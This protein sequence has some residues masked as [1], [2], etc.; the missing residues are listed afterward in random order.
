[1][2]LRAVVAALTLALG[3]TATTQSASAA[4]SEYARSAPVRFATYNV[5][6]TPTADRTDAEQFADGDEEFTQRAGVIAEVIWSTAPDVI[7]LTEITS[8]AVEALRLQ[9]LALNHQ[10]RPA[11][12]YP[13]V[14]WAHDQDPALTS[15]TPRSPGGMAVLSRYPIDVDGVRTFDQFPWQDMP[16]ALVPQEANSAAP[17]VTQ[18]S[19]GGHWD[20]PIT[21]GASTV[22]VLAARPIAPGTSAPLTAERNHDEIRFWSDYV[23]PGA[24]GYIRDDAGGVGGLDPHTPFVILATLQADPHDGDSSPGAIG[25]LLH[26]RRVID[27]MPAS[28][29][30]AEAAQHQGDINLTHQGDPA[31]DTADLPDD[32]GPGNLR[33]DYVLPSREGLL[34]TQSGV[35]WPTTADPEHPLI[36]DGHAPQHRLVWVDLRID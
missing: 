34:W 14:F 11:L 28:D 1:M 32:P 3:C 30:A 23:T 2:K 35:F 21:V 36:S 31:Y 29:G 16:G 12:H 17:P 24:Q 22:H 33:V 26:N 15:D 25:Q 18:L 7:L 6:L 10:G 5:G 27:P 19:S 4:P 20:V 9:H 8:G 13:Y